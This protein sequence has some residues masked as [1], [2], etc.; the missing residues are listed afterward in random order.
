L[1]SPARGV[2]LRRP[3][4]QLSHACQSRIELPGFR[5]PAGCGASQPDEKD[6]LM[7]NK[8][9]FGFLI[10]LGFSVLPAKADQPKPC[11][12]TTGPSPENFEICKREALS[13]GAF[14]QGFLAALYSTGDMA[15]PYGLQ[16]DYAEAFKYCSMAD[17][18]QRETEG[19]NCMFEAYYMGEGAERDLIEANKYNELR[20]EHAEKNYPPGSIGAKL[21]N[22]WFKLRKI[23]NDQLPGDSVAEA[24]RRA[25]QWDQTHGFPD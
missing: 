3:H 8:R 7:K 25:R 10:L 13:G 12:L 4:I 18:H 24:M 21:L 23:L 20:I 5:R 14:A 15:K 1:R 16:A 22:M 2:G 17:G 19:L 11:A 6:E 9:V